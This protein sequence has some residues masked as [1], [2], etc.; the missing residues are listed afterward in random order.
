ML[1]HMSRFKNNRYLNTRYCSQAKGKD[2]SSMISG[3]LENPHKRLSFHELGTNLSFFEDWKYLV[4]GVVTKSITVE[5]LFSV[6]QPNRSLLETEFLHAH[7]ESKIGIQS[8]N[9]AV[10]GIERSL[11][12][13]D[14]LQEFILLNFQRSIIE[15]MPDIPN[16]G[17]YEDFADSLLAFAEFSIDEVLDEKMLLT[18]IALNLLKITGFRV[19]RF[20]NIFESFVVM[21]LEPDIG[22]TSRTD[23]TTELK[24]NQN[25]INISLVK[26]TPFNISAGIE[27]KLYNKSYNYLDILGLVS[28][29]SLLITCKNYLVHGVNYPL[30]MVLILGPHVRRYWFV[31]DNKTIHAICN[32]KEVPSDNVARCIPILDESKFMGDDTDELSNNFDNS[33]GLNLLAK[34]ERNEVMWELHELS[35]YLAQPLKTQLNNERFL[36]CISPYF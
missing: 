35:G 18:P 27:Y 6:L 16:K 15:R 1:N 26:R 19:A 7:E 23:F 36:E 21:D 31:Y 22:A 34:G 30:P 2:V 13:K 9:D 8:Y 5:T 11:T 33:I 32:K 28:I 12:E 17:Y 20:R 25:D 24:L 14:M 29:E 10:P 3:M 4:N